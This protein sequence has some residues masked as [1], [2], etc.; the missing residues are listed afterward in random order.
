MA[1]GSLAEE[2]AGGPSRG[3][4]EGRREWGNSAEAVGGGREDERRREKRGEERRREEK[5]GE[6]EE[7]S[8]PTAEGAEDTEPCG[9]RA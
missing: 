4:I 2:G 5:R 9:V 7:K 6:D 3:R 8:N 1:R